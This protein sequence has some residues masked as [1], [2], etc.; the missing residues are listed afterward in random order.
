MRKLF[1][2]PIVIVF[3]LAAG[4]TAYAQSSTLTATVRPNPLEVEVFAPSNV[5]VGSWFDIKVE[6]SNL[7]TETLTNTSALISPP[8]ELVVR[9]KRKRIGNLSPGATQTITFRAMAKSSGNLLILVEATGK[10][11]GE[12]ISASDTTMISADGSLGAFL[13]RLIFGV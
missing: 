4:S 12:E 3:L 6:V 8:S 9:G 7:G 13:H 10:L 11:A 5:S 2:L 1:I